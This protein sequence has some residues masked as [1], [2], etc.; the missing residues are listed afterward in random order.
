MRYLLSILLISF[1]TQVKAT[2]VMG[3]EITWKCQGGSYVFELVFY[4]DCNGADVNLVNETIEVW[5]HPSITEI[6]VLFSSR[7]DISPFC[8]P[9]IGSPPALA[10]GV[11]ASGGNGIGAF[12]KIVYRSNPITLSG[13]PPAAGWIFTA[14]NFSRSNAITNLVDPSTYGI[15][16]SAYMF[17]IPGGGTGCV[18]SSPTFLQEPN[19]VSCAGSPYTYNMHVVDPDLD[20]VHISFGHP[21]NN[22]SG[23]FNPPTNPI[24]LPYEPGFSATSPT[25][26]ATFNAGNVAATIDPQSGELKFNSNTVG[27]FVVKMLVKSFRNGQLIAQVEREM[28]IV[29]MNCVPGNNAPV[30]PGP[31]GGLYETTINA[32]DLVNFTLASSD[33]ELLQD[34]TPQN[35]ILSAS[36]LMFGTNQTSTTGCGTIPCATLNAPTPITGTQGASTTFNWQTSCDH[37][38]NQYGIVAQEVPYQFVFKV[39]DNFCQ[40]PK[41]SY[42]TI[43]IRVRNQGVV[44]PAQIDCIQTAANGDLTIR[45]TPPLDP[46]NSF[47]S[48][49]IRKIGSPV[50]ATITNLATNSYVATGSTGI[51][52]FY[53]ETL[54]GCNGNVVLS[55]DTVQ[56]IRLTLI[57]PSNGTAVL[58]W[59][60][61]VTPYNSNLNDFYHILREF[62][63]GVW[64][65]IDSVPFGTNIY[66][67]T[68]D[69][70]NAFLSYQ[71]S[72][73]TNTCSF[74]SNIEGDDFEDMFTPSIPVI[75]SVTTDTLTGDVTITWNVNDQDDTFGYII[76][77]TD[78]NG[79]LFEL[80]TI[81]GINNVTYTYGPNTTNG[82]LTFSISAFDSCFTNTIPAT[83]QTSAKAPLHTSVYTKHTYDVCG[84]IAKITWTKYIGWANV[85]HYEIY[86]N[87]DGN[88]WILYGT[89]AQ[90]N[91]Q[92]P[93]TGSGN[94]QFVVRAVSDLGVESF[95]NQIS[96]VAIFPT[97]PAFH[98]TRVATVNQNSILIKHYMEVVGGVKQIALERKNKNNNFVEIARQNIVTE[99]TNF[100]DT[101]VS[102]DRYSYEYRVRII[103][104][105]GNSGPVANEVKTILLQIQSNE[106][107]M[108]NTLNWSAYEGFSGSIIRYHIFRSTN[109]I[110]TW[111][112]IATVSANTLSYQ[113]DLNG[114]GGFEGKVCYYVEAVESMNRYNFS[115]ESKS[116]EACATFEPLIYIPNAFTP[117]GI[118]PIFIPVVSLINPTDYQ[119]TIID[120]WGQVMFYTRDIF[121]GWDGRLATNQKMAETGVYLY[122][123]Q[124]RDGNGKEI[125][126]RGHVSLLK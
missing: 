121:E 20:S 37:L 104:S 24:L 81:Y 77:Q 18:D 33:V 6:Q 4:R 23:V 21:I 110:Y 96:V 51:D 49:R 29:N 119:L 105:C 78:Q 106:I 99:V 95:S 122:V 115:E 123:L 16:L 5:N 63:V 60:Q 54:S 88:G 28:Q 85:D 87:I 45:W 93:I 109:G 44:Q 80:D 102:T 50:L 38:V 35:N 89:T 3:G 2:H 64:T 48:Y 76:Y 47:I 32:G 67:D 57:N 22:F 13:T 118:N 52:D 10:C 90:L 83:Y 17:A 94:Y 42:T 34:G 19:L 71:I 68:I 30:V 86:G 112:P 66:K 116:N 46:T 1:I 56:N 103:D 12:E 25:P 36:G 114:L 72:L 69:I 74:T 97:V 7:T 98:Y 91:F 39:Q 73:P 107:E 53:I 108:V 58:N 27:N 84:Q 101:E 14:K 15:T 126:K 43:T 124:V 55:S 62:P 31:F 82:P 40:V 59:N 113:D 79:I 11:G 120:R 9:V 111:P 61:P 41:V 26:D 70:C 117:D 92:I 125:T 100:I 8:T 65:V 75:T